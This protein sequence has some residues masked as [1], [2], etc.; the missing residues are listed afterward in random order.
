MTVYVIE[1]RPSLGRNWRPHEMFL[2][3]GEADLSRAWLDAHR[4]EM[5]WRIRPYRPETGRRSA[6]E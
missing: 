2:T 6:S 5:E 1:G 3:S 4:G